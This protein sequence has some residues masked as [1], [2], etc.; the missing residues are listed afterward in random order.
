MGEGQ[1]AL[2]QGW[3]S[4]CVSKLREAAAT[5]RDP[6]NKSG[7][8]FFIY[9]SWQ[10][11][12]T[13]ES[14]RGNFPAAR[15]AIADA[16][17]SIVAFQK[18][19]GFDNEVNQLSDLA[20]E[21]FEDVDLLSAQGDYATVHARAVALQDRMPKIKVVNEG[22]RQFREDLLRDARELQVDSALRTGKVEEAVRVARTAV[23]QPLA[24][25]LGKHGK[26][27]S[28]ARFQTLLGQS[29]VD[30]G[31]SSEA[32]APL[33]AA[34]EYYRAELAKGAGGTRFRLD[35]GRTLYELARAQ[36]SDDAGR[37]RRGVLLD[38]ASSLLDGLSF[39]AKQLVASK[40]LMQW[41]ADAQHAAVSA[42][43]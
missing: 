16:R 37:A 27:G 32:L 36:P 4:V 20:V 33:T 29:L 15:A 10:L 25:S 38:E 3:I 6:R 30:A 5:E 31:R 28:R 23:D 41:V 40:E 26:D 1:N 9:R 13:V 11:L 43:I 8:N 22:N 19:A 35:Y 18:Q 24:G 12:A 7:T 42:G 21:L 14:Q 39:E 34:D 2:Q 17:R